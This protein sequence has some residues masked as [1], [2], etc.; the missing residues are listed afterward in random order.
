VTTGIVEGALASIEPKLAPW[1]Q[2]EGAHAV[3]RFMLDPETNTAVLVDVKGDLA[4]YFGVDTGVLVL[5][6]PERKDGLR[7]GDIL[8]TVAEQPITGAQD[9][10]TRVFSGDEARS[11][12]VRRRGKTTSFSIQPADYRADGKARVFVYRFDDRIPAAPPAPPAPP[13]EQPPRPQAD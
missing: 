6:V 13:A 9:A 7:A 8:L 10:Q 5:H 12:T 1:A 2:K 11:V 4:S 3:T